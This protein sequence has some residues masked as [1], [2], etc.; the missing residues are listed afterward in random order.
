[1]ANKNYTEDTITRQLATRSGQVSV[2]DKKGA[3]QYTD[4]LTGYTLPGRSITSSYLVNP[5]KPNDPKLK[6]KA[7]DFARGYFNNQTTPPEMVEAIASVAAYVSAVNGIPIASLFV[8]NKI[9]LQLISA[10]NAFKPK[11]SQVGV[12]A[13][14][15]NPSWVNNPTLRGTIA[16]AITDQ[17]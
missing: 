16:A 9:S 13:G 1:M 11:G 3:Y 15:G 2:T 4:T 7:L 12:F 14:N 10:Y 6:A 5:Q 17:A 8:N